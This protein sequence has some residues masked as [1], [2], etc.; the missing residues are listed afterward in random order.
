VIGVLKVARGF[1]PAHSRC[2]TETI[3]NCSWVRPQIFMKRKT[4][5]VNKVGGPIGP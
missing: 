5:I 1:L 3:A 2:T 4:G